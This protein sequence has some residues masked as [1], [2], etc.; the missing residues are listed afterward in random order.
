[1]EHTTKIFLMQGNNMDK[2]QKVFATGLRL[3]SWTFFP[4][5]GRKGVDQPSP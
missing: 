3:E 2:M 4:G 1:M 5:V